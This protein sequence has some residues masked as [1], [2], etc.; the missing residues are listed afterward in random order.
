MFFE[1]LTVIRVVVSIVTGM[2][3]GG[4]YFWGLWW[5]SRRIAT[6]RAP[7]LLFTVSFIARMAV[8]LG[9][10]YVVTRGRWIET[11]LCVIGILIA[12]QMV[13]ARVRAG[14]PDGAGDGPSTE[15]RSSTDG[16]KPAEGGN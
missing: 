8:L 10:I 3:L 5:T 16:G 12:R 2:V 15:G 4:V 6:T 9:G 11:S 14:A 13:V 1:S 7:G